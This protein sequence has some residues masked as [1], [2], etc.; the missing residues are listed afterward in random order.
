MRRNVFDPRE[1]PS[2]LA[3]HGIE[4]DTNPSGL[5]GPLKSARVLEPKCLPQGRPLQGRDGESFLGR[6]VLRHERF[7]KFAVSHGGSRDRINSYPRGVDNSHA[8]REY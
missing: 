6:V 7:Q 8:N 5:D 4:G 1:P 3:R 2:G